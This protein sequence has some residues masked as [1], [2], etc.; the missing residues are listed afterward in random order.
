MAAL[1]T[2][3]DKLRIELEEMQQRPTMSTGQAFIV[4]QLEVD[5]QRFV[6]SSSSAGSF[7]LSADDSPSTPRARPNLVQRCVESYFRTSGA[8]GS[9]S[10]V[11]FAP[12]PSE[13]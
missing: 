5:R 8:I 1:R 3:C 7:S 10:K 13:V 9:E 6:D 4:F 2:K 11:A 12:E